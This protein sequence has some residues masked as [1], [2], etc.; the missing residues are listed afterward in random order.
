MTDIS[1]WG[2]VTRVQI[3]YDLV[4]L[5]NVAILPNMHLVIFLGSKIAK[6]PDS[7]S[8]CSR[9]TTWQSYLAKLENV[10]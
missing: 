4:K 7:I 8:P 2:T 10:W 3:Q 5:L 6:N 1:Y 9:I